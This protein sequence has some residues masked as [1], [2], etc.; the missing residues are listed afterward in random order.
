M[1]TGGGVRVVNNASTAGG[2][3]LAVW[4]PMPQPPLQLQP[5]I[6]GGSAD[7]RGTNT[8]ARAYTQTFLRHCT[9]ITDKT[10][11]SCGWREQ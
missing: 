11:A 1:V 8:R 6:N 10:V 9:S 4:Q 5:T 2:D 7:G 3:A